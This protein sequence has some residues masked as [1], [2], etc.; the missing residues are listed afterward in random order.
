MAMRILAIDT[1]LDLLS[2]AF[3]TAEGR[4]TARSEAIGKGHGEKLFAMIADVLAE[5]GAT[6]ADADR[7]AVAV[8]P[9]SFTGIRIGLSAARGFALACRRPLVGVGTLEA[10][11]RSHPERQTRPVIAAID[12]RKG[13][14][15]AAA[16]AASGEELVAP[17]AATAEAA[18]ALLPQDAG[19]VVGS[20]APL[21]AHA[22]TCS[23]RR[24][25]E[26]AA[27]AGPDVVALARLAAARPPTDRQPSPLY[28]RPPDAKP[29]RRPSLLAALEFDR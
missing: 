6:L 25:P 3:V 8:G 13:E 21:L 23:G 12:A 2:V 27:L 28:I 15:Y 7:L 26:S 16:Y 10:L 19:L 11:A 22:A 1:S 18:L 17:F 4:G 20:G 9:G 5:A 24:V 14:V 29:G